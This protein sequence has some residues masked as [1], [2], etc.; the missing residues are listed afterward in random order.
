MVAALNL[1]CSQ[2]KNTDGCCLET[3]LESKEESDVH[4]GSEVL[5]LSEPVE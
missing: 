2:R 5:P 3:R 1:G 4:G